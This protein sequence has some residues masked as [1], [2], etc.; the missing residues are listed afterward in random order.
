MVLDTEDAASTAIVNVGT[1]DRVG[2]V[3]D[4]I[5]AVLI[6]KDRGTGSVVASGD[7]VDGREPWVITG[8]E[9]PLE[10]VIL[11]VKPGQTC[12]VLGYPT[13]RLFRP[14]LH[15]EPLDS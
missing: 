12:V 11:L 15:V 10:I 6:R 3:D 14:M 9:Q 8:A 7:G 5:V 1:G 13:V 4:S 2:V